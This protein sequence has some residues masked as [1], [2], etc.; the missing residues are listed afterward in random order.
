MNPPFGNDCLWY[1]LMV[2]ICGLPP[3][4]CYA[5][6]LQPAAHLAPAVRAARQ[7]YDDGRRKAPESRK[8]PA[9]V[10]RPDFARANPAPQ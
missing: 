3:S 7:V 9:E 8:D 6:I 5:Q 2:A 1:V 4:E 10:S